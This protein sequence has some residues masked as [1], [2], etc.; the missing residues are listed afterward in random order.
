VLQEQTFEPVGASDSVAADVRVLAT[1]NRKLPE[2]IAAGR[3]RE[4]L[5]YRLAVV[6][7]EL[8]PLRQRREDIPLLVEHFIDRAHERLGRQRK[9]VEPMVMEL[10][11]DYPWP[12]NV[13][14]LQNVVTRACVLAEDETIRA[15]KLRPWLATSSPSQPDQSPEFSA[16]EMSLAEMERQMILA[17]LERFDGHRAR[18]A[19]ALGIGV[20]TLSGKLRDYG[21]APREKQLQE[22]F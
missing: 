10:L 16:G 14:E 20:R 17:T 3:F 18:T 15:D 7:I 19:G 22:S 6:P 2:E 11:T 8:P 5:Y 4:D 21:V 12:G 13:R 1:T 9:Q